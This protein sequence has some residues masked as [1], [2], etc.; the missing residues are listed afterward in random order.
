MNAALISRVLVLYIGD[1]PTYLDP[2][3]QLSDNQFL[4]ERMTRWKNDEI[5]DIA[6]MIT[7]KVD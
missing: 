7:G 6:E 2:I 5:T 3:N 4:C 1:L